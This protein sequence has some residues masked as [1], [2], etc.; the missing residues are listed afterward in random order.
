M[1]KGV[2]VD[3]CVWIGFVDFLYDVVVGMEGFVYDDV[4]IVSRELEFFDVD[5]LVYE[6][7]EVGF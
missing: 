6:Y 4:L 2:E 3:V 7:D 5:F 1:V